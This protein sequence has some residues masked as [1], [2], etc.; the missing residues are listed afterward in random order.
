MTCTDVRKV[1]S[2]KVLIIEGSPHKNGTSNTLAS[3]F[4]DGARSAGHDVEVFDAAH[5]GI[6]GCLGCG[7]CFKDGKC[8]QKDGMEDVLAKIKAADAVVLSTPMYYFGFSA[9]LKAV[10]DRFYPLGA[11]NMKGKKMAL[12]EA[13]YNPDAGIAQSLLIAYKG[14]A[15]YMG[16]EDAGTLIAAGCGSAADLEKTDFPQKAYD[17]GRSL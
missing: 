8:V 14:I 17:L 16:F 12:L 10:I 15:A 13:Q 11:G 6:K 3:K 7:G 2:M 5:S 1:T 4:A 9:Q